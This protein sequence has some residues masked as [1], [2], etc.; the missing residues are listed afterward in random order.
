MILRNLLRRKTRT[1]LTI[2]GIAVGVA[3]VV[4]LGA[5]AEGFVEGYAAIAGGSGA[6]LL[7]IQD[8]ALDIV[9]SAVDE[10]L[11]DHLG[12]LSGVDRVTG[13]IYTFAAT[14]ETPYF[15]LYGYDPQDFA[16]DHFKIIEGQ[17][18][19]DAAA[20][21]DVPRGGEPLILGRA[22]ADDFDKD[23]GDLFYLYESAYRVVGIYETG[24]P[25]EDGAAVIRLEDAQA[26]SGKPQQVNAFLLKLRP[27]TDVDQLRQRIERR[28]E[29]LTATT[30][31]DF[32]Q[33]Q[34]MLQYVY[35]FSWS[36]SLIA[37]LIGGVGVMNTVLMSVFERTREF[38]VLRAVG[39]R[40]LRIVLMVLS[41]S[42]LISLIG[43]V[44]GAL[45]GVAGVRAVGTVPGVSGFLLRTIPPS[46]LAQG[47]AVAVALGLVGGAFPAWKASRL[48]PAEAI[49]A[50]GGTVNVPRNVRAWGARLSA[51]LRNVLRQ[52][53]RTVLT[54]VG[55]GIAMMA[56]VLLGAMG[57]GLVE[58][59]GGMA[60]GLGAQLVGME[61][62]ASID[63]SK[64]DQDVV[65][66]IETMPGVR[67][68]EG[69]L[70]GCTSVADLPFFVVFGYQPRGLA[71]REYRIVEGEPLTTNRQM[72]LGRVAAENLNLEVGDTMRIFDRAFRIVGI[73]ETGVTFQ[74]GGGVV[75][76]RDAQ[77]LF[78][79]PNRVSFLGIWLE[80]RAQAEPVIRQVEARFPEV[81]VSR[82]SAF[83]EDVSDLEA[84]EAMTWGISLMALVVGGLGMMNT[85]VM[86]VF[87]RTR[88]IGVLR[89][90]GWRRR[91]VL[92]MILRESVA[93][94]LLGG[95]AGSLVGVLL[96]LLLNTLPA[97]QA[98]MQMK[99]S[100]GLFAQALV[101]AVGLGVVG[102]IY[103]AWWASNLRP[104]E[105][106]RYE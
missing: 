58:T 75:T 50:E 80:D 83:T 95:M 97:I 15:I 90:L 103:P 7:V 70:T 78:G 5:L 17:S 76:L 9:F 45:L 61:A 13:M 30:S 25:F 66:R 10:Q 86:S 63:L 64:I 39:W 27:G 4:G 56:I 19:A 68:A 89:A 81:S 38:G 33:Q 31:A 8:E 65:R 92:W 57:D 71:L 74:D 84:L 26:V 41:E 47:F 37:V 67:A 105:A 43:G 6:D 102:G 96:G 85:M 51:A 36:V 23:V 94:T 48:L 82:A 98:W 73:Y 77:R 54:V 52:P 69:F 60:G 99:Y 93:L 22:A 34:D 40:P 29:E 44:L 55:V 18:L 87:E 3:A 72:V 62:G 88:E 100:V 21:R 24:A 104:A 28:F 32:S 20:H 42:I 1:V 11:G 35:V 53:T 49:R 46:T 91:R 2:F 101:T 14:Q 16:I 59:V 12:A 79:Q 106:L